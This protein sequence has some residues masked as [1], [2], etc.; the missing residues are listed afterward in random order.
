MAASFWAECSL[1]FCAVGSGCPGGAAPADDR[2]DGPGRHGSYDQR[3]EW[4]GEGFRY[5][6]AWLAYLTQNALL[7]SLYG[8]SGLGSFNSWMWL[9]TGLSAGLGI[10]WM[11]YPLLDDAFQEV[12]ETLVRRFG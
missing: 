12:R 5:S 7:A 10:T 1:R 6:N 9:L 8:G 2:A 11:L 4:C 3:L